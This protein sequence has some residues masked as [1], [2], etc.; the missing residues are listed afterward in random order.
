ME[1]SFLSVPVITVVG[2]ILAAV[3]AAVVAV[4]MWPGKDRDDG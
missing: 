3:I 2:F 4:A 1:A